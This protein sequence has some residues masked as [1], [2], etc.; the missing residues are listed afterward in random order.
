MNEASPLPAVGVDI[1]APSGV[2]PARL[3][4]LSEATPQGTVEREQDG[5]AEKDGASM[6]DQG[7]A[8]AR[9]RKKHVAPP[10]RPT[11]W[12][13]IGPTRNIYCMRDLLT[14]EASVEHHFV[15]K[16]LAD[17]GYSG[18][19]IKTKESI[20]AL[21]VGQGHSRSKHKPDYA[22]Y[23]SEMPRC[24]VEAKA[25]DE[26]LDDWVPQCSGYCLAL[27]QRVAGSNPVRYF[28]LSNGLK[29]KVYEWDNETPVLTLDF[30]DFDWGNP[31]YLALKALL[32]PDK[33]AESAARE[34]LAAV[35]P[36]F[37]FHRPTSER[38]RQLFAL[39][40]RA[41][42]KAEVCSPTFAFMEFIKLMFVKLWEDKKLRDN[43]AT[44][45][46][47]ADGK[48]ATAL[49]KSAVH[50]S[51]DWIADRVKEGSVNPIDSILFERLRADIEQRIKLD[52][53][54]R[55]FE[56]GE[57]INLRP[58][59]VKEVVQRLQHF[60]LF[61]IDEDLNGRLFETFLSATMRGRALGQFFTPRSVVKMMTRLASLRAD[62]QNQ[63]R[64]IDGCC[65]SGGFL[66]EALSV[67]RSR[68]RDNK[69]LSTAEAES[70]QATIRN[71]CLYGIDYGKEPPLARIARINMY[72]HGDGGS[73]VYY[74]DGLDKELDE[75]KEK[76]PEIVKDILELRAELKTPLLFDVVLTNPPFSMTK[77]TKS[78]VEARILRQYQITRVGESLTKYRQAVRI[79]ILFLER[80]WELL[81]PGGKLITVIDDTLLASGDFAFVRSFLREHY[82]V[83]AIISLPSDTFRRSGSRVKTSVLVL[84]K[85]RR[86]EEV[87]PSC[88]AFFSASLGVDD[89]VPRASEVEIKKAR[90]LAEEET[91]RIVTGYQSF[92]AGRSGPLVLQ[93]DR[94][95]DRL[96]LKY[97]VPQF[98]RMAER[99][100]AD[101]IEVKELRE[102][103][104]PF[105]DKIF[106]A[107]QYPEEEFKWIK[108]GYDGICRVKSVQKGKDIKFRD[109]YRVKAGQLVFSTFRATDGAIGIVPK[110]LDGALV[111]HNFSVFSCGGVEDTAY[112][113]SVLR[114]HEL[115][116]DMQSLSPGS[117]RYAT[118]WPDVGRV[119]VPWLDK[120]KR[121]VIGKKWLKLWKLEQQLKDEQRA[122][123]EEIKALG[124]ES[125]E[126]V[127]RWR[128]SKAPT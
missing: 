87:Q 15:T 38:T 35:T 62:R 49:P 71:E 29:T 10:A 16:L 14:N 12:D 85:K 70:L 56:T 92:L 99:W 95:T 63:D 72:L 18:S 74:A 91:E 80:Y 104:K 109:M 112:L 26:N 73:R 121:G 116:A 2:N 39:C 55:L 25:P 103:V 54:K 22:L 84:E 105:V 53:K 45:D 96:D 93:P 9:S 46:Y 118:Y 33:I 60:D 8:M 81:R 98:G 31:K 128:A 111:S 78:D 52:E 107:E 94:L 6:P 4:H 5:A 83:R 123:L 124:V 77:A 17:L 20:D 41:I 24:V 37:A 127:Y 59:T 42:W 82:L 57:R 48:E 101:G 50:F 113:W 28:V 76:D 79:S 27:N 106:P 67:M 75:T 86:P 40:H 114:S 120:K 21:M 100:R 64:V 19:Q 3:F 69:S 36:D 122:A 61:G 102:C 90:S 30:E 125:P 117:S 44:R 89:L 110:E 13:T 115:R 47:F 43:P 108:V 7:C 126:S 97:C 11:L 66:I 1:P 23:V 68:V 88:F 32:A 65:G 58:D 34:Q 51:V 119:L